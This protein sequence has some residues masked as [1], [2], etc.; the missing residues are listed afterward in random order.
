M[1]KVVFLLITVALLALLLPVETALGQ[2]EI[3]RL[4]VRYQSVFEVANPPAQFEIVQFVEEFGYGA[5][6]PGHSHGGP[7]F[8]TVLEGAVTV[9][10]QDGEKSYEAG[11]TF[12]EPAGITTEIG[13]VSPQ[14]ARVMLT[15]LLPT[16]AALTT[17]QHS[18]L[19]ERTPVV[20]YQSRFEA[21]QVPGPL[22]LKQMA[23]D[24]AP[25]AS[26]PLHFYDGVG[27]ATVL[28]GTVTVRQGCFEQT[29]QAGESFIELPNVVME[30][31]NV[32][33]KDASLL[34]TSLVP[35]ISS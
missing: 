29:Y 15:F 21:P 8:A 4:A 9:R 3:L 31:G 17:R 30:V 19:P 35:Q 14:R 1:K 16:G 28:E 23:V 24:L 10:A 2:Q 20:K 32:T 27:L 5:W 25:G 7:G 18:G 12:A 34:I 33:P 13:N 6:L 26:L 22:D 11:Q